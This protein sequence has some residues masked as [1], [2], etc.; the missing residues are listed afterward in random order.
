MPQQINM[1]EHTD[2]P[3]QAPWLRESARPPPA[4]TGR[5]H[6]V[7]K[8]RAFHYHSTQTLFE[9][10]LEAMLTFDPLRRIA[11][12]AVPSEMEKKNMYLR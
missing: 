1:M 6:G 11:P 3:G 5:A 8:N 4:Y 12:V 10:H 9:A 2:S 7:K